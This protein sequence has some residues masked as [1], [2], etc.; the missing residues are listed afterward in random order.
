MVK[1]AAVLACLL[2]AAPAHLRAEEKADLAV[3]HRIKTEAFENSQ[4]MDHLFHLTDVTGPRVTNSP[5]HRAAANWVV[6]RLK[7]YGIEGGRLEAWP[8]GRGWSYSRFV[9][10]L[11]EPSDAPLIG[12]P[13]AWTPSTDGRITGE[14]VL[15]VLKSED[16]FAKHQGKLKGKIVMIDEPPPVRLSTDP[17]AKR[18]SE[19]DLAQRAE[20]PPP[21]PRKPEDPDREKRRQFASRRNQFLR[22]EGALAVLTAGFR[23]DAN[24]VFA[25]K[26]GSEDPKE[27]VP[28]PMVALVPVHYNRMARF[29]ERKI[30]VRLELEV[31]AGFHDETLDSVNVVAE[32]PGGRKRDEIVMLGAHLDSWHGGTGATD[33]GAG[34]AVVIE[35]LRILKALNLEMDRTVR[36]ALWGGEEQ[37]LLG[38]KAYVKQHFADPEA[39]E[40]KP[41]HGRLSGYFNLDNGTG[42]IRGI[43]LQG[44]DMVRPIFEAWLAPFRDLGATT[45]TIRNTTGTDHL[46]FDAVGLPGFQFIQDPVE[47]GTRTHHSN[48]DVYDNIQASDLMQ[49]SAIMAAFVY[50]AA[51]REQMLPRKP[52]PKPK[53]KTT[54]PKQDVPTQ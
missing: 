51:V 30:P 15:A 11:L 32:I 26:G 44:N 53:P 34:C 5:Q 41:E 9:A 29:L 3:I 23:S 36:L 19:S 38:S 35:A 47:Y 14:P 37:G 52:L 27:P 10:H 49:A 1:S 16:D 42:R 7:Q 18:L 17:I 43:Y 12:F 22:E 45:V 20:A 50:H 54:E 2:A 28:P 31:E 40:P 48:M 39:M 13:L 21:E 4:V 8:F 6:D 46:S 33:N 25:A 24:M